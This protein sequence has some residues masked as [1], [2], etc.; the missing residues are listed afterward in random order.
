M[1]IIPYIRKSN[2]YMKRLGLALVLLAISTGVS[3]G[4]AVDENTAKTIGY[5]YFKTVGTVQGPEALTSSYQA[6]SVVNG[7]A[8]TDFYV[9]NVAPAGF[10]MVSGD[11]NVTPILGYATDAS[12]PG[13]KMPSNVA[14][15]LNNYTKQINY[16]IQNNIA[17]S[18]ATV[19]QW[20][21]LLTG[22]AHKSAEKT[23]ATAA[24]L[25]HSMWNQSPLYNALCPYDASSGQNAVTGCVATAMA[26]VMRY[27]KW[28]LT[29]T[30]SNSYYASGF[31]EQTADFG[32]TTYLWDSM[33]YSITAVDTQIA[34]VNYQAGVSVNMGLWC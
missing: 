2:F 8:V 4:K 29:G 23:T 3:F 12:F 32:A 7:V 1:T 16:G 19:A 27:W 30:G 10:V 5:N 14:D 31:G 17:P 9:F 6:T 33:K 26:Q 25:L 20:S 18:A 22:T 34:I 13:T 21:E 15:W 28:P 24:P 11:D